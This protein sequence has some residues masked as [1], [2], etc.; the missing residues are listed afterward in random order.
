MSVTQFDQGN[1]SKIVSFISLVAGAASGKY[2]LPWKKVGGCEEARFLPTCGCHH[3]KRLCAERRWGLLH[4]QVAG[5]VALKGP[6]L[7]I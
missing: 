5:A 2:V 4:G 7:G 6:T 3:V 1:D